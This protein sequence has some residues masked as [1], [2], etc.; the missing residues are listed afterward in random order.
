MTA[1]RF[2]QPLDVLFL[3]NNHLFGAA[4]G[5]ASRAQMPPWPSVFAGALRSRMLADAGVSIDQ[6]KTNTLPAPLDHV[7][8]TPEHPGDFTLADLCLARRDGQALER[9]RPVPADLVVTQ[10]DDGYAIHKLE[11]QVLPKPL[12]TSSRARQLPIPRTNTQAKH[13]AGL[14]LTATGW[15]AHLRG[16]PLDA[17]QHL[18]PTAELWQTETRLGIALDSDKRAAA[19]GQLYTSDAVAMQRDTG[20]AVAVHGADDCLPASG[21]LRLGGDGRGAHIQT[22]EMPPPAEPDWDQI[23][24]SGRFRMILTSP[25]LFAGG[26]LPTGADSDGGWQLGG[27]SAQLTSQA[28]PRHEVVSGWDMHKHHP[29]P[30]QRAAPT[31]SVYWFED[32]DGDIDALRKLSETG[33]WNTAHDNDHASRRAEGFNRIAIANV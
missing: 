11:P 32:F 21:L 4:A 19:D 5:D 20:F 27:V 15:Q 30:A 33:L 17:A 12:A 24:A 18:V 29:K 22:P 28:V 8:G 25:G 16:E 31:G 14:W 3:R 26:H 23:R 1:H 13:V 10:I 7:L 2:I 6:L 9:L